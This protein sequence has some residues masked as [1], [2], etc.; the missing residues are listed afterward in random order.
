[1]IRKR[2][3]KI[4][5]VLMVFSMCMMYSAA[6]ADALSAGS[7]PEVQPAPAQQLP[8]KEP[9][10]SDTKK[11][12]EIKNLNCVFDGMP[13]SIEEAVVNKNGFK[14]TYSESK[15]GPFREK[16][17]S[18][19]RAGKTAVYIKYEKEG[20]S[21]EI[22]TKNIVIEPRKI[23]IGAGSKTERRTGYPIKAELSKTY[24]LKG[25]L[26]PEHYVLA[27]ASG[28][29]SDVGKYKISFVSKPKI[30][31]RGTDYT[32]SYNITLSDG[33]LEIIS[34]SLKNESEIEIAESKT[35]T[36]DGKKHT[37]AEC[38]VLKIKGEGYRIEYGTDNGY[39]SE[40][41]KFK[42]ART[43]SVLIKVSKGSDYK[44]YNTK[45][46]IK[47]RDITVKP[48]DV[49]M[50]SAGS[51]VH[52]EVKTGEV[53]TENLAESH[54]LIVSAEGKADT[55]GE[56]NVIEFADGYPKI[57]DS[58]NYDVTSNYNI[59]TQKGTLKVILPSADG[60]QIN[61]VSKTYDGTP[62]SMS[63]GI[64]EN[65]GY[66]VSYS[67]KKDGSYTKNAPSLTDAGVLKVYIKLSRKNTAAEITERTI[68]IE[69]VR[70]T[71][72][73]D[74]S[75]VTGS[76][77]SVT[78][79]IN[80]AA[81]T[82][83]RLLPGH[84]LTV[85]ASGTESGFGHFKNAVLFEEGY[86]KITDSS[87]RDKTKNYQISCI[88][89]NL[90]IIKAADEEENPKTADI[91]LYYD[92]R[93]HSLSKDGGLF[94]PDGCQV[95]FDY[96]EN[97]KFEYEEPSLTN[98]G[99]IEVFIKISSK[100]RKDRIYK[101]R[102]TI[103]KRSVVIRP[104]DTDFELNAN[105]SSVS[106]Y[107]SEVL[108]SAGLA[109]GHRIS[110]SASG[111]AEE[112]GSSEL[113][114][115][116]GS[117]VI[118]DADNYD[119]TENY[120]IKTEPGVLRVYKSVYDGLVINDGRKVYDGQALSL[121][122]SG[123]IAENSGYNLLFSE[124]PDGPFAEKEPVQTEAGTKT[125]YVQVLKNGI[126][127]GI[128]K[129][130]L[131]VTKRP[132]AVRAENITVS[133]SSSEVLTQT[134]KYQI[135]SGSLAAGHEMISL[136][137]GKAGS[138]GVSEIKF[139]SGYPKIL[140]TAGG[141]DAGSNY[142]LTVY[143]G[144][145]EVIN[146]I[147]TSEDAGISDRIFVYDAL[148]HTVTEGKNLGKDYSFEFSL[149]PDGPFSTAEPSLTNAGSCEI[150]VKTSK[151]NYQSRIF[152]VI[153]RITPLPLTVQP[154]SA[155]EFYSGKEISVIV[156]ETVLSSQTP[157]PSDH[158]I[159]ASASGSAQE[160]GTH[161]VLTFFAGPYVADGSGN[162]VS[163]NY[164]ITA[165]PGDLIITDPILSDTRLY[166]TDAEKVYD[167][168]PLTFS[169]GG[170]VKVNKDFILEYSETIDGPFTRREPEL[171]E[172][173]EKKIY[174]KA[175]KENGEYEIIQRKLIVTKR[176]IVVRAADAVVTASAE[177]REIFTEGCT[178]TEGSVPA[179]HIISA[180]ASAAVHA[181]GYHKDAV[182]FLEN[183]PAVTDKDSGADV[184]SNYLIIKQTGSLFV[185]EPPDAA[186]GFK[187]RK[188]TEIEYDGQP[189]SLSSENAVSAGRGRLLYSLEYGGAYGEKEP[190]FTDAGEYKI[191]VKAIGSESEETIEEAVLVIS[192]RRLVLSPSDVIMQWN[193]NG[194][195]A[196]SERCVIISGSLA[197]SHKILSTA[198]GMSSDIG[199]HAVL[200]FEKSPKIISPSGDATRNYEITVLKGML[201][202]ISSKTESDVPLTSLRIIYDG[203][204][205]SLS[206]DGALIN[207]EGC[208]LKFSD[209]R[210]GIFSSKEPV[211]TD[212]GKYEV[213]IS[214]AEPG[215]AAAV[216]RAEIEILPRPLVLTADSKTYVFTG[217][218]HFINTY[219]IQPSDGDYISGLLEGHTAEASVY[220]SGISSENS[221]YAVEFEKKENSLQP[222]ISVRDSSGR[223]VASNYKISAVNGVLT[224]TDRDPD[225]RLPLYIEAESIKTAYDGS[226]H[227]LSS[228]RVLNESD[229]SSVSVEWDFKV[230]RTVC[231]ISRINESDLQ[232]LKIYIGGNEVTS[233]FEV[234]VSGGELEIT[235][236]QLTVVYS[237]I[238]REYNGKTQSAEAGFDYAEGLLEGDRLSFEASVQAKNTGRYPFEYSESSAEIFSTSRGRSVTENYEVTV[239][240]ASLI[241]T[242]NTSCEVVIQINDHS[243]LWGDGDPKLTAS[244][245]GT[246]TEDDKEFIFDIYR[247]KGEDSGVYKITA[248][249]FDSDVHPNNNYANI[250]VVEGRFAVKP[251]VIYRYSGT[252]PEG[253][254]ALPPKSGAAEGASYSVMKNPIVNG[255]PFSGWMTDSVKVNDSMK[256][257]VPG[258]VNSVTFT[259]SFE[260]AEYTVSYYI[261]DEFYASGRFRVGERIIPPETPEGENGLT[262]SGWTGIPEIMPARDIRADGSFTLKAYRL[263]LYLDNELYFSMLFFEGTPLKHIPSP[264]IE[265][266]IFRGWKDLPMLMPAND[267]SA[268]SYTSEAN[269]NVRTAGSNGTSGII[270]LL[271]LVI[272]AV[273][274]II[275]AAVI[276]GQRSDGKKPDTEL[277]HGKE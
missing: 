162:D 129:R 196:K 81:V 4:I 146:A 111:R 214:A 41:P 262:F 98:A 75:V 270:L 59:K 151:E 273:L 233:K 140:D 190:V 22:M 53:I 8:A 39:T 77:K 211:F 91:T 260:E 7:V 274:L 226:E 28:S 80:N 258:N 205:H 48:E 85:R 212:A 158:K 271:L 100:E 275:L 21:P 156:H 168:S 221:P 107:E 243:K 245:S 37:L 92:G 34:S 199:S 244:V 276:N 147:I 35:V 106:V 144:K 27:L 117:P 176:R 86:P 200:E 269:E 206:A 57:L 136:A 72:R 2:I 264:Q 193:E 204:Q 272:A 55:P 267:V 90:D 45:L 189:H 6:A 131:T 101:A 66:S 185:T 94:V 152:R 178:V 68:T 82:E 251:V 130:T 83:G 139:R 23:T 115:D 171:T 182:K 209:S 241:I 38:G 89:G 253:A 32:S 126:A 224:V 164:L 138:V 266:R 108:S 1:M 96:F 74:S 252:V 113:L 105:S 210:D 104:A 62:L 180:K 137:E 70:I 132:L 166:I 261:N 197:R 49:Q 120:E 78:V 114:F 99:S 208:I 215:K 220:G 40:E 143:P 242:K 29:G 240:N 160:T 165:L 84:S 50:V 116:E 46:T 54:K 194:V 67:L 173:G 246:L 159:T 177:A 95:S 51:E 30:Y 250:T 236:R 187:V 256:F 127:E 255:Y 186:D 3:K 87:G 42:D 10:E 188:R 157:L 44:I 235:R 263:S 24:I 227:R 63:E 247:T 259:G 121:S 31:C 112:P 109:E 128:L 179:Q 124:N 248:S 198:S 93:E 155:A 217:K 192:R 103:L 19:T 110:S 172:A 239:K 71:V 14:I 228:F 148:P 150:Y 5:Y 69:P 56:H 257:A 123:A 216:H 16:S 149:S 223:D 161:S 222:L 254:P 154:A 135:V 249:G 167:G 122:A 36:Y 207:S 191:F 183:Y 20:Y 175:I 88:A 73:A 225:D 219:S 203:R 170:A 163:R 265:G 153:L 12:P 13:H 134:D 174:I 102:L 184:S 58:E 52:A 133:Y 238:Y 97:G 18:R 230:T 11:A 169:S 142:D 33:T 76:G 232:N 202:I 17:P 65:N 25:S 64:T 119:V 195:S 181:A 43:Y 61:N 47:K 213:Y 79:T 268:N 125:V 234:I 26:P 15:D 231:G 201:H 229:Y 9:A 237:D 277:L 145:L 141:R 118:L 218:T 60:I